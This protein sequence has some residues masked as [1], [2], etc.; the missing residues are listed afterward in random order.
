MDASTKRSL[1]G[2]ALATLLVLAWQA[3]TVHF[4]AGGNWT[5][6]YYTGDASSI[7]PYLARE[8]IYQFRGN[9]GYDGQF[10][11]YLAHD[12]VLRR[13]TGKYLDNPPLRWRRIL[14]PGLAH[15]LALGSD[16]Y[17][18][19]LYF[20]VVLLFVFL[21]SF[22]LGELAAAAGRPPW[23]G[24]CFL[25]TPAV[26]VS[27]DRMTVDVALAAL[28]VGVLR[29]P[30]RKWVFLLLAAAALTR[31][32]GFLLPVAFAISSALRKRWRSALAAIAATLPALLW[33]AFVHAHTGAD[34]TAWSDWIPFAGIVSRT[35][36]P[37]QYEVSTSWLRTAAI[38]D[39]V[40]LIGVWM[41]IALVLRKRPQGVGEWI[42]AAFVLLAAVLSKPDIWADAYAFGRT[43]S[44]LLLALAVD[45]LYQ[46]R[47][48]LLS[49]MLL[50]I[51]R[52]VFQLGP[53]WKGILR[54]IRAAAF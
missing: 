6:L 31:E 22:G 1:L 52:I 46:R 30:H 21:G 54:G 37:V 13:G 53:Q 35:L 32:S 5:A 24:L 23:I 41:A 11:H 39:Y 48:L 51:P 4:N 18:D 16:D 36:H 19:S 27:I 33:T 7:P 45:G 49:P 9:T 34:R 25:L 43:L 15:A 44:P 8:D 38:L 47:T 10:Y 3:A 20:T 17:V 42:A 26:A 40:A 50:V 29:Y 14:V 12:P 2:A 28:C